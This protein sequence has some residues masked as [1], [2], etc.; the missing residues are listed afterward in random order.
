MK[1]RAELIKRLEQ[2]E[3]IYADNIELFQGQ[4]VRNTKRLE[5]TRKKLAAMR[6]KQARDE[7][8]KR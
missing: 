5:E 7:E 8:R 3:L 4:V 6:R 2:M 1:T